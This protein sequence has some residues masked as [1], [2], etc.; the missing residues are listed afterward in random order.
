MTEPRPR[1]LQVA[2][3][4]LAGV[5]S[6]GGLCL[7][8][9]STDTS[10]LARRDPAAA[11]GSGGA[12]AGGTDTGGRAG[13]A[14]T[15]GGGSEPPELTGTGA[16][17]V[18]HGIVDGGS[19]FVCWGNA[20]AGPLAAEPSQPP[21]GLRY[22]AALALPTDWDLDAED[23]ELTLFVAASSLWTGATCAELAAA[24][25][26]PVG[27]S[28]GPDASAP[29]AGP[30]PPPFPLEP[31]LPR[32][33][34]S[35]RFAPGALRAGAHYGLVAAGCTGPGAAGQSAACGEP[36]G[37]FGA[38]ASLVLAE[39]S[40]ESVA[41][42][43]RLGLQFVNASRAVTR[44][45]LTLQ[46]PAGPAG[47]PLGNDVPFGAVR[48]LLAAAVDEPVGLELHVQR[49]QLSSYTQAWSETLHA[50]GESGAVLGRNHLVAYV[51]PLPSGNLVGLAP[52]RFVL[53][54]G[55]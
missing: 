4:W 46:G 38:S 51:G 44:A 25:L 19:L 3:C 9:C 17:G 16:I 27:D 52:P 24:S 31:T 36:D 13:E 50:R 26:D 45:D 29:D 7:P 39:I 11:A 23:R 21:G 15:G 32:R 37:A 5:C 48:P 2:M 30:T 8:A 40:S 1:G 10:G 6:F 33:A 47:A 18:V 53:I 41:R 34:G 42:S 22:G 55:R 14:A 43:D 49:E 12:G 20:E 28:D 35:V 54:G